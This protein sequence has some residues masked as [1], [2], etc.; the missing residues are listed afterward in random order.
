MV[1]IQVI[2]AEILGNVFDH[3]LSLQVFPHEYKVFV[4]IFQ[5]LLKARKILE[6]DYG[7]V[8][9]YIDKPIS[10]RQFS[11]GKIDRVI[12]ALEPRYMR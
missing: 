12:H 6:E 5:G 11:T 10:I 3:F 4:L 8:H 7:S 1:Y 9:F 2:G